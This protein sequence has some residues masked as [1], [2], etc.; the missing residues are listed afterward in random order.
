M[1]ATPKNNIKEQRNGSK[2][3]FWMRFLILLGGCILALAV[4]VMGIKAGCRKLLQENVRF[5]VTPENIAVKS[6]GFWEKEENKKMFSQMVFNSLMQE[7]EEG[8]P[9]TIFSRSLADLREQL[10]GVRNFSSIY[11][12]SIERVLPGSL[13]INLVERIPR[14]FINSPDFY[15]VADE[16]AVLMHKD[17][18]LMDNHDLP[19]IHTGRSWEVNDDTSA[20]KP[21]MELL[22][23]ARLEHPEI[24]IERVD[25]FDK[26]KIT[27]VM[28]YRG[29]EKRYIVHLK[30][31]NY[32]WYLNRISAACDQALAENRQGDVLNLLYDIGVTWQSSETV[33][34]RS[35]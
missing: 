2:K 3:R 17:F 29:G 32:S 7:V 30:T 16:N 35:R 23:A 27:F 25:F 10:L 19:V 4:L 15:L 1:A 6:T 21:V 31:E 14:A 11:S 28:T 34:G 12:V 22:T 9:V 26:E 24:H 33:V 18:C 20:L 5:A 13:K 8:K